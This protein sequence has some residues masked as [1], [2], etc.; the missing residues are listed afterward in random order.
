MQLSK[1]IAVLCMFLFSSCYSFNMI[2]IPD[3][4]E[5][6]QVNF[7]DNEA[8]LVLPSMSQDFTEGLKQE[9]ERFTP[10]EVVRTLGDLLFEGAIVGYSVK[11]LA[12]TANE[13]TA[14]NRLTVTVKVDFI[15]TKNESENWTKKFSRF[16]D[17]DS[18]RDLS[19]VQDALVETILEVLIDDIFNQ[20]FGDW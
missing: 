17:F 14:L 19:E 4:V 3:G 8:P 9:F 13:T 16:E 1:T 15:N 7:F 20:A 10:L 5:T 2:S 6:V 18:S 12:P 11:S